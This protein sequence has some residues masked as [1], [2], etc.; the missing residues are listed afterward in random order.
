MLPTKAPIVLRL[1]RKGQVFSGSEGVF[2]SIM[3]HRWAGSDLPG[4]LAPGEGH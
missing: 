2:R 3:Q 1:E 4:S